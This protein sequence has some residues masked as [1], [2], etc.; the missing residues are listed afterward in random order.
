VWAKIE[1]QFLQFSTPI[2]L[3][4]GWAKMLSGK[5]ERTLQPNLSY[6]FTARRLGVRGKKNLLAKLKAYFGRPN[7]ETKMG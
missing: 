1:A 3:G 7:N 6:T 4:E 5:I 2:K